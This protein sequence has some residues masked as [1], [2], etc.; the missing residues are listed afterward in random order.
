MS[1]PNVEDRLQ[2]RVRAEIRRSSIECDEMDQWE[3]MLVTLTPGMARE[4]MTRD[5]KGNRSI[6]QKAVDEYARDMAAGKWDLPTDAIAFNDAGDLLNGRH[7]LLAVIKSGMTSTSIVLLG[8]NTMVDIDSGVPRSCG[9]F[10]HLVGAGNS[11]EAAAVVRYVADWEVNRLASHLNL[12]WSTNELWGVWERHPKIARSMA[13]VSKFPKVKLGQ[14]GRKSVLAAF[15]YLFAMEDETLADVYIDGIVTGEH[16]GSDD[17]ALAVRD[18]FVN[19]QIESSRR[20]VGNR[21]W[22]HYLAKGWRATRD[23]RTLKRVL[24]QRTEKF[25]LIGP[26]LSMPDEVEEG[27]EA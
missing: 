14:I 25:P 27:Q 20:R 3:V 6:R 10:F 19:I 11:L 8:K 13:F 16:I 15:H 5:Y 9:A 24:V 2:R 21:D 22:S 26:E 23:G 7:R 1:Q 12:K 4:W 17:A 18:K